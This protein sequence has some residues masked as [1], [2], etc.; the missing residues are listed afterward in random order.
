MLAAI[1]AHAR[2]EAPREC[3]GL[4]LGTDTPV[5]DGP[6]IQRA[7]PTRNLAAEATRYDID[8]IDHFRILRDARR[9]GLTVL[10]AYHSHPNSPPV[11]SATD[12]AEGLPNFL[13]VIVTLKPRP[14]E[15]PPESG[16]R[17]YYFE[18]PSFREVKMIAD[19]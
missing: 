1:A 13:Y 10:G 16:I 12:L 6:A 17:A 3:C 19:D 2:R 15:W 7:E 11:P 14:G 18:G 9:S 5:G 8:P 4:L